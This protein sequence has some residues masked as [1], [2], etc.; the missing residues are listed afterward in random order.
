MTLIDG[1]EISAKVKKEVAEE[2]SVYISAG[3]RAPCLAVVLVG[4]NEAS[5]V[6]V[7][8]K[9]RACEL[10]GIT[11]LEYI[12][13]GSTSEQELLEL[14]GFLNNDDSVDGILVQLPLPRQINESHITTAIDPKKDV[15]A[16][17]PENVGYMHLGAP[18]FLPCTPAGVMRLLEEY[19]ITVSGRNCVVIGRSNIVG[20]PMASLLLAAN[21]TVTVAHS[22]TQDI[23]EITKNAD[24]IVA[25]CGKPGMLKGDM[26]KEGATLIDVGITNV[27][28]KLKGDVD[29]DSCAE[30]AGFITPVPGGVGPM[31]IAM[32]MKNALTAFK[33]KI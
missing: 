8:N 15:D 2:V 23:A 17:H 22:K 19:N 20:K 10:C 21:G 5:K 29:F 13:D 9:K 32:L 14:I 33:M 12:L 7:R 24:I 31:T 6:Y 26:I 11:S 3:N 25:A 28:G 4:D 1:K 27:D 30:K 18:V 16:F